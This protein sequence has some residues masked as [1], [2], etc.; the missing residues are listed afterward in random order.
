MKEQIYL[1]TDTVIVNLSAQPCNSA[2]EIAGSEGFSSFLQLYFKQL[3]VRDIRVYRWLTNGRSLEE[4]VPSLIELVRQLLVSG[5]MSAAEPMSE[6]DRYKALYIVE[7]CYSCWR[8]KKRFT[9]LNSNRSKAIASRFVDYDEKYC[10]LIRQIYRKCRQ[11]LLGR[12]DKVYRQSESGSNGSALLAKYRLKLPGEYAA[13]RNVPF[14]SRLLLHTPIMMEFDSSYRMREPLFLEDNPLATAPFDSRDYFCL[15]LKVGDFLCLTYFHKDYMAQA[16][17]LT[18]L[19]ELAEEVD[20]LSRKAELICLFGLP[21]EHGSCGYYHDE[22]EGVHLA[23]VSCNYNNEHF[24]IFRDAVFTLHN[25][26]LMDRDILPVR[27]A[28]MEILFHD[29]SRKNLLLIGE[30]GAGKSETI[31]ALRSLSNEIRTDKSVRRVEVVFDDVGSLRIADGKVVAKGSA[32]GGLE[33]IDDLW[34]SIYRD[35]EKG[36]FINLQKDDPKVL[37]PI[38]SYEMVSAEHAVD[39]VLYAN[40]YENR[41]G[42]ERFEKYE[43]CRRCLRE[44]RHMVI[45]DQGKEEFTSTYFANPYGPAQRE[46]QCQPI[47]DQVFGKLYENDVF[48]GQLF[49]NL[50]SNQKD[51]LQESAR[52][53][54]ELIRQLDS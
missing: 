27:G 8:S 12:D 50:A 2:D 45:D 24:A 31:E 54:W 37:L 42:V 13:L 18:N 15:P 11:R 32:I 36:I 38:T 30:L 23:A 7:D 19:F 5:K 17:C 29:D 20:C 49:T 47:M 43:D 35:I 1:S 10:H 6:M 25:L 51:R 52:C 53:L 26:A 21:G 46:E 33:G 28:M 48:V 40:N 14:I 4:I 44:G 16:I 9:V 39:M 34:Q 3:A 41:I 22:R